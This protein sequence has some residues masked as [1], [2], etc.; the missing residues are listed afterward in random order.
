MLRFSDGVNI[1]P[2]GLPRTLLL[3]DGWYAVGNGMCIPCANR[4]TAENEVR[5]M[6]E[7]AEK[8]ITK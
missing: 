8:R 4:A 6:T 2:S 1:D 5:L 7:T 3:K